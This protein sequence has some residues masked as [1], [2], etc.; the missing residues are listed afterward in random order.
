MLKLVLAEVEPIHVRRHLDALDTGAPM[1]QKVRTFLHRVFRE[2]VDLEMISANPVAR[3]RAP[4]VEHNERPVLTLDEVR[5][6]FKAAKGD[7]LEGLV[8]LAVTTGMRPAEMLGLRRRDVYLNDGFLVVTGDLVQKPGGPTIEATKTKQSRRR[9]DLPPIALDALRERLKLCFGEVGSELVLRRHQER[10]FTTTTYGTAGGSRRSSKAAEIAEKAA[11]EASDA[12][13]RFPTALRLYDLRHT[14][15]ALNAPAGVPIQVARERM[16]TRQS[17][18]LRTPTAISIRAC[19][20][21]RQTA[22]KSSCRRS[23]GKVSAELVYPLVY[24]D[25]AKSKK[26]I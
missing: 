15:N 8:V 16:G 2:A 10:R 17:S 23:R 25:E 5:Y 21:K 22:F 20:A 4:R 24:G 3:V 11:R 1:K 7:R 18:S 9:I 14:A 6:L 13:Y 26:A 19:N 12:R